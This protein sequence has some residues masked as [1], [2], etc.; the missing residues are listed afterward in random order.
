MFFVYI[1][2]SEKDGTYYVGYSY[3]IKNRLKEHNSGKTHYT[4]GHV[5][6]KIVYIES[7]VTEKEAKT[8]ETGIKKTKNVTYFL[9]KQ[10]GSPD[11]PEL[12]YRD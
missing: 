8:R 12:C 9:K 6:Y 11:S 7:F 2:Q 3:D 1:L 10:V 4:K 5:P